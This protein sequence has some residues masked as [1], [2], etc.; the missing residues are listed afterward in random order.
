MQFS[1]FILLLVA[2]SCGQNPHLKIRPKVG[3]LDRNINP[4][5]VSAELILREKG[6]K[7]EGVVDFGNL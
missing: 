7:K 3:A 5:T 2:V 4:I 6:S 1:V